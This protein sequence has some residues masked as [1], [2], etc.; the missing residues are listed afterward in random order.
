MTTVAI[1]PVPLP[2]VSWQ[3]VAPILLVLP[4]ALYMLAF[5][6]RA[7][8]V[9]AAAQRRGT[10]LDTGQLPS[11]RCGRVFLEVFWTTLRTALV[12]TLGTMLLGYPVALALSRLRRGAATVVLIVVL[13]PFW[14]SVLVRSYA[15]M[16]L[17]GRHGRD[18]RTA[19][20][21]RPD[22]CAASPV[23]H[24][25]RRAYRDDPYTAALH[26]PADRQRAAA[27][28]RRFAARGGGAGRTSVARV[29]ARRAAAVTSR[30]RRG[31]AAGVRA[32][33]WLLHHAGAG[34]GAARP[35]AVD[36]DRA[37]GRSAELAVRCLSVRRAAR[38]HPVADRW[39][40]SACRA[41]G[42]CCG[43]RRDD[44]ARRRSAFSGS[45]CWCSWCC[46]F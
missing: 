35:H 42:T 17:L 41:C 5:Y 14:T 46:R 31:H 30:C 44:R 36:A 26:D 40:S 23:E 43:R 6:L 16:V 25:I 12:V 38:R 20:R 15:W 32:V 19:D 22:R 24:V 8:C 10:E 7:A 4:L 9:D 45:S 34:R 27:D 29:P 18:Q 37:A 33:A 1:A 13:L 11:T 3:R 2:R 21:R 39:R 28:R